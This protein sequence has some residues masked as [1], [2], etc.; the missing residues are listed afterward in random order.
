MERTIEIPV[1]DFC[2]RVVK[3]FFRSRGFQA[4][5][6]NLPL[7]LAVF[8]FLVGFQAVKDKPIVES[9]GFRWAV[10]NEKTVRAQSI[11]LWTA[12]HLTVVLIFAVTYN[13]IYLLHFQSR[14]WRA[15]RLVVLIAGALFML[16]YFEQGF[17]LT[18]KL[19]ML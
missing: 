12:S 7:L 5:G 2:V 3:S 8:G 17:Y 14:L 10:V 16:W 13:A 18:R 1:P 9:M 19:V 15:T 11:M 4:L 6:W